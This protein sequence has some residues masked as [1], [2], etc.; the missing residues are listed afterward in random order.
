MLKG[1]KGRSSNLSGVSVPLD[2]WTSKIGKISTRPGDP[3]SL[4]DMFTGVRMKVPVTSGEG[5]QVGELF[6]DVG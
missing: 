6:S 2:G 5:T 1:R 4:R 3:R